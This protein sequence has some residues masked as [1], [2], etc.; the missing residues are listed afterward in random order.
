M[1]VRVCEPRPDSGIT[2]NVFRDDRLLASALST[3][4][5]TIPEVVTHQGEWARRTLP[6]ASGHPYFMRET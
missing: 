5:P 6:R 1:L 4:G 3:S 2:N